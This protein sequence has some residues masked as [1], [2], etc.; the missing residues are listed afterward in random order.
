RADLNR[1][2]PDQLP[3]DKNANRLDQAR[4]NMK[5]LE[6]QLSD[7]IASRDSLQQQLATVPAM[8]SVDRGPQV[9]VDASQGAA[10]APKTLEQARR[11][12]ATLRLKYTDEYPDVIAARRQVAELEAEARRP[13]PESGPG[14]KGQIANTVYD[15]LKLRL[16]DAEGVVASVQR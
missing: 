13:A 9:I 11:Q 7:S 10:A 2:Y 5:Q 15:Q 12:L 1:Q 3:V 6:L 16:A 14:A 4:A 8:L